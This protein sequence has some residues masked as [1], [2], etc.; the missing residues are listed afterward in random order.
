MVVGPPENELLNYQPKS[1]NIPEKNFPQ[2]PFAVIQEQERSKFDPQPE[3]D[4]TR[5][6][7]SKYERVIRELL[8]R[9]RNKQ[10]KR[11]VAI[12]MTK[13]DQDGLL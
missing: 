4:V 6:T 13:A 8:N 7:V 11:N 1:I 3:Y 2:D 5:F 9:L 10:P 12:C